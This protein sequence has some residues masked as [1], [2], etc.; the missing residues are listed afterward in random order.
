MK[1]PVSIRVESVQL[2]AEGN[3][4]RTE[5]QYEGTWYQQETS[6]YVIYQDEG[7]QTT[8]RWDANEWRLF[9]RG[10]EL[11]G[12]QLFRLDKPTETELRVQTSTLPLKTTTHRMQVAPLPQ[13]REL[14]LDYT[15]ESGPELIGN[16]TLIIQLKTHEDETH[17]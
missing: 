4:A 13:G 7:V 2:D 1:H 5:N 14:V 6:D 10:P 15:L 8:L 3:E 9:R 11:E 17:G 12:F 16:F